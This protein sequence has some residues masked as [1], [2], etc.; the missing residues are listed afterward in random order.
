MASCHAR[1]GGGQEHGLTYS[2]HVSHKGHRISW[3][4]LTLVIEYDRDAKALLV[5]K[6]KRFRPKRPARK[7]NRFIAITSAMAPG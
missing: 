3:I 5:L 1:D 7:L 6:C 2:E 4:L